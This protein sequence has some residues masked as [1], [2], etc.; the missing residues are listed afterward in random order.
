MLRHYLLLALKV[1]RR[2]PFFTAVSLFGTATTL[3]VFIVIAALFDHAFGPGAP[4]THQDRMLSSERAV[5]FGRGFTMGSPPGFKLLDAYARNLPG[6]E[7][8]S[9][10]S[11]AAAVDTFLDGRRVSI[12]LKR[13]DADFWH[14]FDFTFLEGRPYGTDD[15]ARAD[16]VAVIADSVRR[17]LLGDGPSVGRTLEADGQRF[18]I[19]GVV[20]D[21]SAM[22]DL[23]FAD[24][25]VP[26]TT[27]KSPAYRDQ[28]MGNFQA[29][30]L[31]RSRDDLAGIRAEFNA[32]L[33]RIELPKGT[34]AI[35]A[36][37]ETRL[38]SFARRLNL[39]DPRS[40]DSQASLFYVLVGG[41][42]LLLAFLPAVNLVN[43]NV[44]RILERTSEIGVRKAF[45]ASSNRLIGQFVVEN[46]LLT[47]VAGAIALVGAGLLLAAVNRSGLI[48]HAALGISPRVAG[49]GVGLALA[50]GLAS[51]VY[52]AW[53][54]S[55]LHPARALKGAPR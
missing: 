26:H 39:G 55:R 54:M 1:L 12:S 2:R 10:F 48:A 4:D 8:L 7:R 28:L 13:T 19:V 30:V 9:L 25:W 31:G 38:E 45:G 20:A 36:P 29:V 16:F 50:F 17:Q 6:A 37:F 18:R 47:L 24:L 53:R 33:R 5:M 42:G 46:V 3:V 14:V 23:P 52:P 34:E 22:R 49:I 40:P 15:V 44:S 51:G 11:E 41:L 27:S 21:V 32:R 43:L 35:V